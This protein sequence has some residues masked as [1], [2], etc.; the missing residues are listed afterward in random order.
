MLCGE[1]ND[2]ANWFLDT[3]YAYKVAAISRNGLE[4]YRCYMKIIKMTRLLVKYGNKDMIK[5]I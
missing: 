4:S 3:L 1:Y 5:I 2:L